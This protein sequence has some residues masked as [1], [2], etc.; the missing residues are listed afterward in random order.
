MLNER[1]TL[2]KHF[3]TT[4]FSLGLPRFAKLDRVFEREDKYILDDTIFIKIEVDL[5]GLETRM[6]D[7][8]RIST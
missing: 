6:D 3:F 4:L 7:I 5:N 2:S 1:L 8:V